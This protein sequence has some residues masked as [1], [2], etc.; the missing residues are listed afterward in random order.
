[1][2]FNTY[3]KPTLSPFGVITGRAISAEDLRAANRAMFFVHNTNPPCGNSCANAHSGHAGGPIMSG[4]PAPGSWEWRESGDEM[5]IPF[6]YSRDV[7][8]IRYEAALK[9]STG[10]SLTLSVKLY[11]VLWVSDVLATL[12]LDATDGATI[13]TPGYI[14]VTYAFDNPAYSDTKVILVSQ[15]SSD[16]SSYV[17]YS[18]VTMSF[19]GDTP[20]PAVTSPW[21]P[22][23]D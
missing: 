8:R 18:R 13:S 3:E 5:E 6:M 15:S 22:P 20:D 11:S 4:S 12:T 1:M 16:G 14:E 9:I 10:V 23:A 7:N 21:P 2:G 19:V 17:A